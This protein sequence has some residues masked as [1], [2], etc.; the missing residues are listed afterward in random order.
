MAHKTHLLLFA[1][2]TDNSLDCSFNEGS[3]KSK[4]R[5]EVVEFYEML[6]DGENTPVDTLSVVLV[7]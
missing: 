4:G 2:Q 7:N 6:H 5:G 1:G 3:E